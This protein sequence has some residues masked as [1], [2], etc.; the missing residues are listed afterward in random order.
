MN[1]KKL[2]LI[3]MDGWG[4]GEKNSGNAIYNAQIP[5]IKS[6]YNNNSVLYS[7]LNASGLAVGL[8][9]GQMGNSEV[10]HL[11]FGAGRIVFQDLVRISNAIEDKSIENNKV[12]KDAFQYAKDHNAAVHYIGLISDGGVHSL[13]THLYKLCDMTEE[14]GVERVFIHAITDGRDTDPKSGIN[15][16]RNLVNH[17][18]GKKTKIATL[19]GRYFT[20][21]RDKRWERVKVGYDMMVHGEG[22]KSTDILLAIQESYDEGVTDEFIRPVV[23]VDQ[24]KE[25][26]ATIKEN[27]VV[28]CFNFRTDR[29]REITTVLTQKDMPEAGMKTIP[30]HYVTMTRYNE[31]FQNIHVVFN[32]EDLNNTLGEVLSSNGKKQLRIAETEKYPHVTFFFSG[33]R[34]N[35]FEGETRIMIPSPKVATY[36]LQPGMSAIE[37]TENVIKALESE[38]YDFICLN[39]ANSDMVG[40]TGVYDAILEA[41]KTVDQCVE[42]V[43]KT[44]I[45]HQYSVILTADH[46]NS[47]LAINPDGSPNTA[48]SCNPVPCFLFDNDY[49]AI[50][51]GKL[52]DI[53]PTI[54]KIMGIP[55]PNEMTG[56]PLV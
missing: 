47:D 49:K 27:D 7:R 2:I 15:Y 12:L 9:D 52:A 25:V 53:A 34:E 42:K 11:N 48:H 26:L 8:P 4:E 17:I 3:I 1:S 40:H 32:N 13:D 46:G 56:N 6:L 38:K 14:A 55:A 10:G 28:I 39:F 23:F 44:A 35:P 37:V 18:S 22:K 30:L 41:L 50:S 24:N 19:V 31:T 45:H 54:L 43:V 5:F 36:D 51:E 20:M 21:D 29:L 16:L 33:G